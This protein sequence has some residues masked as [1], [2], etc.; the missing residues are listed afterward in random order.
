MNTSLLSP[1]PTLQAVRYNPYQSVHKGLRAWLGHTLNVLG[2]VDAQ[3]ASEWQA[4][5][6]ALR[7][8]LAL[9]RAH[10]AHENHFMHR[11]M[12]ARAPGSAQ[13]CA[14]DHAH[15][16]HDIAALEAQ[17]QAFERLSDVLRPRAWLQLYHDFSR[18]VADNLTHMLVEENHN[19]AVLW[20]HYSDDELHEISDA[21]VASI[22]AEEMAQWFQWMVPQLS[23]PER[24][25]M[26][27]GMQQN[28]PAPVFAQTLAAAQP[29]LS[30]RSWQKLQAALQA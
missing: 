16:E 18:F 12:E 8:L 20:A 30:E 24:V 6:A 25:A 23:H 1:S 17:L 21:L 3:D 10:L 4:A 19:V 2:Q 11:A 27:W 26:F 9:C 14:D 13:P 22:P 7:S 15:H 29:L 5:A 28:M